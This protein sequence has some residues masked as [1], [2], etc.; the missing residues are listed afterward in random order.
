MVIPNDLHI[1]TI[2]K[3]YEPFYDKIRNKFLIN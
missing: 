3:E 1:S 2:N